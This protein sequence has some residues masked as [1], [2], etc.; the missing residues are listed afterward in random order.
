M[1][2]LLPRTWPVFFF[3][4]GK[5]TRIQELAIPVLMEGRDALLV[6]PAATGKTEAA[7][8]PLV[9]RYCMDDPGKMSIIYVAPTRALVN[10]IFS[11]FN[12]LLREAGLRMAIKTG[13]SPGVSEKRP[14]DILV[15]TPESLD[16]MLGRK[17]NLL[18]NVKA[19][20]LDEIHLL[21]NSYRGDQLIVLMRRLRATGLAFHLVAMSATVPDPKGIASRYFD[22]PPRILINQQVRPIA[23]EVTNDI[24]QTVEKLKQEGLF[25]VVWF[26]NSRRMVETVATTLK[27]G[28]WRRDRVF[29]HHASL[30]KAKRLEVESALQQLQTGLCVA[31]TTLE[32]GIDIGDV[33]AVVLQGPPLDVSSYTQRTGRGCRRKA[34]MLAIGIAENEA[35]SEVFHELNRMAN[36]GAM[37]GEPYMADPSVAVQ[38]T[39]SIL[40][41][42]PQG[43]RRSE[44]K[45]LLRGIVDAADYD[46][47]IEHLD[48]EGWVQPG[49]MGRVMAT[50]KLMD[51]AQ[52]GRIHSNIPDFGT[53]ELVDIKTSRAVGKIDAMAGVGMIIT[54]GGVMWKVV[55]MDTRLWRLF[56]SRVT[57]G[58]IVT[59]FKFRPGF[60]AFYSYLPE[61]VRQHL[62]EKM[63]N[64]FLEEPSG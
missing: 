31:T 52:R 60:G 33:D 10:N 35:E 7:L 18:R 16:S 21:D 49:P 26:C 14:P 45:R 56:V 50:T 30:P 12:E 58:E 34:G 22:S 13:D 43:V 25:K 27:E 61:I 2:N 6:S 62:V 64:P 47:I 32:L 24:P 57:K 8:A 53:W 38:Q 1:R 41:E 40:F 11:R 36:H 23:L 48:N 5:P 39:F 59:A 9:E 37:A 42:H 55:S 44:L 4:F 15:T 17:R 63:E 46:A 19:V 54:V 3:R 28:L 29:V 20:V 51:F